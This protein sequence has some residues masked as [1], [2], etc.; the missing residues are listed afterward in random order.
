[1]PYKVLDATMEDY[2]CDILDFLY[3]AVPSFCWEVS[4]SALGLV[5][6]LD[7]TANPIRHFR[8]FY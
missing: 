2:H 1:M 7:Q 4:S 3:E 6:A 8:V 5:I